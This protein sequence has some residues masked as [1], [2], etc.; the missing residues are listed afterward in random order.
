MYN[1]II[2]EV[3]IMKKQT[4]GFKTGYEY[5]RKNEREEII[6]VK[7]T[8]PKKSVVQVYFPD[9][10]RSYAYYNDRFDLKAGDRVYVEGKLQGFMG[11]VTEV[12]YTF[13]IDLTYYK[14]VLKVIDTN[15]SGEFFIAGS[16]IITLDRNAMPFDK[17]A[18]WFKAPEAEEGD[19]VT[20]YDDTKI[21]LDGFDGLK[22]NK[23]TADEGFELYNENGVI[24]IS[25]DNTK[26]KALVKDK[27]LHEVE[28][29]FENGEISNITCDC[30]LATN[31]SHIFA[32]LLQLRDTVAYIS[33]EVGIEKTDYF[34]T[35][36]RE[37]F[38]NIAV[39]CKNNSR[40]ILD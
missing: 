23:E 4:I 17:V 28:F 2:K 27:Y 39:N 33:E 22:I 16:H 13:K 35:M 24:Y 15:V 30:F 25:I 36:Y 3:I 38:F 1:L 10:D 40:L 37:P 34:S 18:D 12:N 11:R 9:K 29:E 21:V 5:E 19:I 31:C 14:R 8:E 7:R 20:G 26:G 6:E 32:T